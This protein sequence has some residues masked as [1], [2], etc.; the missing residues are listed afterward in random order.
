MPDIFDRLTTETEKPGPDQHGQG[1]TAKPISNTSAQSLPDST[2]QYTSKN[3]KATAQ[4]LIKYGLLEADRKPNLYEIAINQTS[5]INNILEPLDLSLKI[6][7]IRGLAFL[8]VSDQLF[9]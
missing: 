3:L 9:S 2:V 4:E 8:V 1:A 5:A 7:D 6:D